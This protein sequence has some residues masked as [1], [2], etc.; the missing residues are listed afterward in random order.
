MRCSDSCAA[1][2]GT[3]EDQAADGSGVVHQFIQVDSIHVRTMVGTPAI[4][5]NGVAAQPPASPAPDYVKLA[6]TEP[7]PRVAK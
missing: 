5:V 6:Q 3:F 2:S 4:V 7:F 1:A